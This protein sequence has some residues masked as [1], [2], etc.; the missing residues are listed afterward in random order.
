MAV[1]VLTLCWVSGLIT[2]SDGDTGVP[3][4]TG[5]GR[6]GV[7]G[8]E[9]VPRKFILRL[10][11]TRLLNLLP[12]SL[13]R[14]LLCSC[15]AWEGKESAFQRPSKEEAPWT[16]A[17]T[18]PASGPGN[19]SWPVALRWLSCSGG[20]SLGPVP[21][22]ASAMSQPPVAAVFWLGFDSGQ[23]TQTDELIYPTQ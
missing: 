19:R 6:R 12:G 13:V 20:W 15:A 1:L 3:E 11:F 5:E 17:S 23:L 7:G 9:P 21:A 10:I 18:Q 16:R 22:V 14:L 4:G 2:D 8:S